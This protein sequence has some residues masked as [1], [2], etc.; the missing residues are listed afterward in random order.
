MATYG[1]LYVSFLMSEAERLKD[2]H[3]IANPFNSSFVMFWKPA[4]VGGVKNGLNVSI[5][6]SS[7]WLAK[8]QVAMFDAMPA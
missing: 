2:V 6:N 4:L 7:G 5:A 8:V 1:L 3:D